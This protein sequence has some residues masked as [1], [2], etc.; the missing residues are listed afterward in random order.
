MAQVVT[1]DQ[2][3]NFDEATAILTTSVTVVESLD[4]QGR[5]MWTGYETAGEY[6]ATL[7]E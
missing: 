1:Y 3:E 7:N 2:A 5:L 4:A 6:L